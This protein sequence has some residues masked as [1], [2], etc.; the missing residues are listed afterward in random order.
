MLCRIMASRARLRSDAD[1]WRFG[2]ERWAAG[3]V[4]RAVTFFTGRVRDKYRDDI[5]PGPCAV[6][7]RVQPCVVPSSSTEVPRGSDVK[8]P[9]FVPGP[10]LRFTLDPVTKRTGF[11]S[12][13]GGKAERA[14]AV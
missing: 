10:V 7:I 2:I 8:I 9:W 11:F 5:H 4:T 12:A 3:S 1:G 14:C 6:D 13:E